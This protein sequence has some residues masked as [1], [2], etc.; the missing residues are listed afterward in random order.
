MIRRPLLFALLAG[1][2]SCTFAPTVA[3]KADGTVVASLG[4]SLF[5]RA[6]RVTGS[7]TMADGTVLRRSVEG[8]DETVVPRAAI[9]GATARAGITAAGKVSAAGIKAASKSSAAGYALP[10][11]T[12]APAAAGVA[13]T[14]MG[15]RDRKPPP[16]PASARR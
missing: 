11:A 1:V 5:T 12:L 3:H 8:G 15:L 4:W 10:A 7:V 2:A 16:E 6:D 13:G 9:T 14:Y